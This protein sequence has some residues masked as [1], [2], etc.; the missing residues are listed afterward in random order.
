ME[1]AGKY[2]VKA[3][4]TY[5]DDF[6]FIPRAEIEQMELN[7]ETEDF[8][9][10]LKFI[11]DISEERL[12]LLVKPTE[13][14]MEMIKEEGLELNEDGLIPMECHEV[15]ED[16]G[17]WKYECGESDGETEYAPFAYNEDGDLLYGGSIVLE[18]IK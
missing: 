4:M 14:D 17:V 13:S 2:R 5:G 16:G 9:N 15:I 7:E 3:V 18:K 6:K 1:F 10:M 12:M 11:I 8:I